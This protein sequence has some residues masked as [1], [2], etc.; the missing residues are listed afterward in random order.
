M[1]QIQ[2]E[3]RIELNSSFSNELK[4]LNSCEILRKNLYSH[5]NYNPKTNLKFLFHRFKFTFFL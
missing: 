4:T 1:I 2:K 5:N 3:I